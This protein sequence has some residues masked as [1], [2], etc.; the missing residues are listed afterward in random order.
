MVIISTSAHFAASSIA[1]TFSPSASAFF[2]DGEPG[3]RPTATFFAP[4]SRRFSAWAWP[5]LP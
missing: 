2:A 3:R 4:E 1:M 5:W